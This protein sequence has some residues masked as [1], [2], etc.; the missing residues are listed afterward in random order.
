MAD[1]DTNEAVTEARDPHH[2]PLAEE[3]TQDD[4]DGRPPR[5][6]NDDTAEVQTLVQTPSGEYIHHLRPPIGTMFYKELG[7]LSTSSLPKSDPHRPEILPQLPI[8]KVGTVTWRANIHTYVIGAKPDDPD[9]E[10]HNGS[11]LIVVVHSGSVQVVLKD[12]W[13]K[14]LECTQTIKC[15]TPVAPKVQLPPSNSGTQTRPGEP[16][17]YNISFNETLPMFNNDGNGTFN[18]DAK[19]ARDFSVKGG[20]QSETEL[21]DGWKFASKYSVVSLPTGF[22]WDTC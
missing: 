17:H 8:I 6:L 5:E 14:Y 22:D 10:K 21:A 3:S 12:D 18:F 11:I 2:Q 20:Q 4:T 9:F 19:Y 1:V 13:S 15:P 7:S 16:W